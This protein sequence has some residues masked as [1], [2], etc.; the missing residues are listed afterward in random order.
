MRLV[1][2]VVTDNNKP[3]GNSQDRKYLSVEDARLTMGAQ[4]VDEALALYVAS[5]AEL[6][7]V[8]GELGEKVD[9]VRILEERV[10]FAELARDNAQAMAEE[11]RARS[12]VTRA[13]AGRRISELLGLVKKLGQ[14][15]SE[16]TR[17]WSDVRVSQ[18]LGKDGES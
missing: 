11:A 6:M 15:V 7:A 12:R 2:E 17:S 1:I 3:L 9:E 16:P 18:I 10:A 13:S 4:A 14:E 8:H 5:R